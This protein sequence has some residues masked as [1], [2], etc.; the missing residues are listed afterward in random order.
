MK[1]SSDKTTFEKIGE[2]IFGKPEPDG[3]DPQEE[4]IGELSGTARRTFLIPAN[5]KMTGKDKLPVYP[6]GAVIL[7]KTGHDPVVVVT[8]DQLAGAVR[9]ITT[10]FD[11]REE[12]VISRQEKMHHGKI[13][14]LNEETLKYEIISGL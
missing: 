14:K 11:P 13:L 10:F 9:V 4:K 8:A 5:K 1:K 12:E 7:S 3:P 6:K 2:M